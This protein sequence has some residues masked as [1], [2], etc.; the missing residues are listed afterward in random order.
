MKVAIQGKKGS[1]SH[2]CV[3]A[4]GVGKLHDE[5]IEILECHWFDDV[6]KALD[7]GEADIAV[8]PIENSIAG[9]IIQ[10]YDLITKY[11]NLTVISES[12]LRIEHHLIAS[13]ETEL[14]D[15]KEVLSH[16][17]AIRQC[18][19]FLDKQDFVAIETDDTAG[20]VKK[21]I[22]E[23]SLDQAAIAGKLAQEL[24]GGKILVNNIETDP[25]NYTRFWW[26]TR[27][28]S[29]LVK[30][31][32]VNKVSL[33]FETNH[34]PGALAKVL[35]IFASANINLTKIESRPIV[36]KVW[37]YYF[38]CDFVWDQDPDYLHKVLDI[39]SENTVMLRVLGEYR[40]G[41]E[42]KQA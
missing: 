38:Y 15:I 35:N 9:T 10:S 14:E 4:N 27:H 39:V 34:T 36:G 42:T 2:A 40:E 13:P 6:F 8:C 7:S 19:E 24:Y 41:K 20:S 28:N 25:N 3:L 1:F 31:S 17:M 29:P 18:A 12:Y 33:L 22:E 21:I 37:R 32:E 5:Q 23:G 26:I 11:P 16:P 30:A